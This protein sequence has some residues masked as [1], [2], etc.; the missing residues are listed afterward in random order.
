M[1]FLCRVIVQ[2]HWGGDCCSSVENIPLQA[3]RHSGR[4]TKTVRLP[5]GI[6]FTF[7]RISQAVDDL[8]VALAERRTLPTEVPDVTVGVLCRRTEFES[9]ISP[10]KE[11][12]EQNGQ[13]W[14]NWQNCFCQFIT[15]A[16]FGPR[17][18]VWNSSGPCQ[19][20]WVFITPRRIFV[21][22]DRRSRNSKRSR[23]TD[24]KVS[25]PPAELRGHAAKFLS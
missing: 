21:V 22:A 20:V 1:E 2:R 16:A 5:T 13:N 10:R 19:P 6:A 11:A 12:G 9:G 14:Q 17:I 15:S 25:P 3:E 4:T 23:K 18:F 8:L 24:T 7:D